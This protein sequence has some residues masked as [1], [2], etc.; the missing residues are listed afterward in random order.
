[1]KKRL[2]FV[3]VITLFIFS[4]NH[5]VL[6][7]GDVGPGNL[8]NFYT[9]YEYV[10][11]KNVKDKNSPESH[12]LEYS[13]K[14]DTLYAEFDNEYI[15]SDLKGKNVDVFGISYKYGSNSRTIYGGVT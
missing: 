13:Y 10:N 2:L 15:T 5:T 11:L 14:N 6:S 3:I 7:N 8:R 4:S 1:M 12:R 9:K